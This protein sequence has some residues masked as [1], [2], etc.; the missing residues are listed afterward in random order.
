MDNKNS[1]FNNLKGIYSPTKTF[2]DELSNGN[3]LLNIKENNNLD[4]NKKNSEEEKNKIKLVIPFS[5]P[6]IINNIQSQ[7]L[8][9]IN[10]LSDKITEENLNT[11][12]TYNNI[13]LNSNNKSYNITRSDERKY[14][15]YF[16]NNISSNIYQSPKGINKFKID[17]L[18]S[19]E[20]ND[21]KDLYKNIKNKYENDS[22]INIERKNIKINYEKKNKS[23]NNENKIN[24]IYLN[25][26]EN[27]KNCNTKSIYSSSLEKKNINELNINNYNN[28]DSK[29]YNI[30]EINEKIGKTTEVNTNLNSNIKNNKNLLKK[31]EYAIDENGNPFNLKNYYEEMKYKENNYK[32]RNNIKI[33][34]AFI[35]QQEEKDKNY[36]I[37]LTGKII[38]KMEDGY[39]NYKHKNIRIIIKDFDVQHPEL[40]VFGTT[41]L[42]PTI[43]IQNEKENED[44]NITKTL[45]IK[46]PMVNSNREIVHNITYNTLNPKKINFENLKDEK[47]SN[48]TKNLLKLSKNISPIIFKNDIENNNSKN[49]SYLKYK[50][51]SISNNRVRSSD[52]NIKDMV[53]KKITPTSLNGKALYNLRQKNENIDTIKRTCE[54]LNKSSSG[55][56][57]INKN[58]STN[59]TNSS[60]NKESSNKSLYNEDNSKNIKS[61]QQLRVI[62]CSTSRKNLYNYKNLSKQ[63][64]SFSC[65]NFNNLVNIKN[66][67]S[68]NKENKKI[69]NLLC[70]QKENI[71]NNNNANINIYNNESKNNYSKI[72][73]SKSTNN[74]S[75][76]IE[77]IS[78]N[79]KYIQ[80]NIQ[81]NLIRLNCRNGM[82]KNNNEKKLKDSKV[83]KISSFNSGGNLLKES[84]SF[85][86]FNDY[87]SNNILRSNSYNNNDNISIDSIQNNFNKIMKISQNKRVEMITP[88]KKYQ[89]AILSKEVDD[90]ISDYSYN[91]PQRQKTNKKT[92]KKIGIYDYTNEII[93]NKSKINSFLNKAKNNINLKNDKNLNKR[94]NNHT[95]EP[96]NSSINISNNISIISDIRNNESCLFCGQSL[97]NKFINKGKNVIIEK[98][99]N[100]YNKDSNFNLYAQ[101]NTNSNNNNINLYPKTLF[102]KN[103][104]FNLFNTSTEP[105]LNSKLLNYKMESN[106]KNN[107]LIS[108]NEINK[109]NISN[110]ENKY[111]Q[112]IFNKKSKYDNNYLNIKKNNCY[113]SERNYSLTNK[114]LNN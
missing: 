92:I 104:N 89:C 106:I 79:I 57:L 105:K 47:K 34:V 33:P 32:K 114:L 35:I 98:E 113:Y 15:E 24:S 99:I 36:L 112:N 70:H 61:F 93:N 43:S 108:I 75:L 101:I 12:N 53:Y 111:P 10:T 62:K 67:L 46:K 63:K 66:I 11:N 39:F 77:N 80:K 20:N 51:S 50:S 102:T 87:N 29:V 27:K 23:V 42:E 18:F 97:L 52:I 68:K 88:K 41:K 69:N 84:Q 103:N 13:I 56:F 7:N 4:L 82:S 85:I 86:N 81:N 65:Q 71:L 9:H 3:D 90:I 73:K 44:K 59:I 76:T 60:N 95:T 100:N 74:I 64:N 22:S 55:N 28:M 6:K 16:Q 25:F 48:F 17:N 107:S 26:E 54:I 5:E 30:N 49:I 8:I 109:I 58:F 45:D 91:N 1:K 96:N 78:K 94:Y 37:D 14:D 110:K 83:P 31:I 2:K 40:R 72:K 21:K 38:P 19:K